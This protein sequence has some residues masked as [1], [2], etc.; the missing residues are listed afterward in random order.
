MF[1]IYGYDSTGSLENKNTFEKN[2]W[3]DLIHPTTEELV[4]V[5]QHFNIPFEFLED[6]LDLEESA[7]IE[8]DK[9]TQTTLI[10][11]DFPVNEKSTNEIHSFITIP[12][13]IVVGNDFVITICNRTNSISENLVIQNINPGFKTRFSLEILLSISK[14]YLNDLKKI[15]K[16]RIKIENDLRKNVTKKQLYDLMEIQKSL[17]YFM[18]SLAANDEVINKMLRT[19]SLK[20]YEDDRELLEDTQ[21]ENTQARKTTELYTRILD[22]VTDSYSSLISNE[23][24]GIMKFLALITVL[25]TIP[26]LIFSFFGMNLVIPLNED[27][28]YSWVVA[29]GVSVF[30]MIVV[31][32]TLWRKK[33]M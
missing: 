30:L 24:N 28:P 20:F 16:S 33:I 11:N 26:T 25:L 6:P 8:Y 1:K 17:V 31:S 12:I 9:D 10:I 15:N 4:K 18:T 27:N 19:K 23:M 21:I 13:G 3:V 7:R 2:C 14:I 22:E 32:F 5:S 29:V